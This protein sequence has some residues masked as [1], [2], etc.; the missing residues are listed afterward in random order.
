MAEDLRER[1]RKLLQESDV[2]PEIIT[3]R[4][5]DVGGVVAD[6]EHNHTVDGLLQGP[7]SIETQLQKQS[8]QPVKSTDTGFSKIHICLIVVFL[9]VA[10]GFGYF[11]L[12]RSKDEDDSDDE[13]SVQDFAHARLS[14]AEK[15]PEMRE[16]K[17]DED[18]AKPVVHNT[19]PMFQPLK[20][21]L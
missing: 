15:R 2:S 1:L 14:V 20:K 16:E 12:I 8:T 10:V 9:V 13:D 11:C 7:S 4:L 18:V 17:I 3:P 6:L 21:S 19:D 5:P